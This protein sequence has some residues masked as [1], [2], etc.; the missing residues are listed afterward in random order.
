MIKS[1]ISFSKLDFYRMFKNTFKFEDYLL[2]HNIS[3]SARCSFSRLRVSAQ[4]LLVEVGRYNKQNRKDRSCP[5]CKN[6]VEDELHFLL[7]CK[8]LKVF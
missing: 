7:S 4:P 1:G 8:L 3:R 2:S 5:F 6:V